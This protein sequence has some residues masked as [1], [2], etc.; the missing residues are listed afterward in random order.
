MPVS[1]SPVADLVGPQQVLAVGDRGVDRHGLEEGAVGEERAARSAVPSG[2][3]PRARRRSRPGRSGSD[4]SRG[5]CP[6]GPRRPCCR[7]D[8]PRCRCRPHRSRR[9][10]SRRRRRTRLAAQAPSPMVPPVGPALAGVPGS[11]LRNEASRTIRT[12]AMGISVSDPRRPAKPRGSAT[13]AAPARRG[14]SWALAASDAARTWRSRAARALRRWNLID[15]VWRAPRAGAAGQRRAA[16]RPMRSAIRSPGEK[17]GPARGTRRR[18]GAPWMDR[19][20]VADSSWGSLTRPGPS[21]SHGPNGQ[22]TVPRGTK[23]SQMRHLTYP[24]WQVAVTSPGCGQNWHRRSRRQAVWM[25][26]GPEE[27]S[28]HARRHVSEPPEGPTRQT[29]HITTATRRRGSW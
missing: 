17:D 14:A 10:P 9:W 28:A 3:P 13:A 26:G 25:Q 2:R 19:P 21:S 6:R 16:R 29:G 12:T 22:R 23:M 24:G 7:R 20:R 8:W 5:C 18:G 1:V 11:Q 27:A 15:G 4:R